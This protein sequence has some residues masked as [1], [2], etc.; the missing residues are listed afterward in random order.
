MT[1]R[2]ARARAST[3]MRATSPRRSSL[4]CTRPSSAKSTTSRGRRS[5]TTS[6]WPASSRR[7]WAAS[8]STR[9]TTGQTRD[10]VTT[11]VT[12]STGPSSR[13]WDGSCPSP[14]RSRCARRS[15]GPS[16]TLA[17]W[18]ATGSSPRPRPSCEAA[19]TG[20]RESGSGDRRGHSRGAQG[21]ATC[22]RS[23][24]AM[25]L[26]VLCVFRVCARLALA[27]GGGEG[28]LS[29]TALLYYGTAAIHVF[30]W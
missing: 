10:P 24:V 22:Q 8:W 29:L 15:G 27:R 25:C 26:C 23:D 13:S 17:G 28:R 12:R 19:E 18:T 7:S 30:M 4:C 14:L 1:A 6:R 2:S 9:C 21:F 11:C 20:G 5:S 16:R 3:S